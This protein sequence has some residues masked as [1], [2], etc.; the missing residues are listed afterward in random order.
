MGFPAGVDVVTISDTLHLGAGAAS[1]VYV[2]L[3]PTTQVQLNDAGTLLP[4]VFEAWSGSDGSLR[5]EAVATDSENISPASGWHYELTI[6]RDNKTV[7]DAV[8]VLLPKSVPTLRLGDL[9]PLGDLDGDLVYAPPSTLMDEILAQLAADPSSAV[10]AELASTY[11]AK[12]EAA[13][14]YAKRGRWPVITITTDSG[15]DPSDTENYLNGDYTITDTDGE[16]LHEGGLRLRGRGNTTWGRPKKPWR[17]NFDVKTQPLGMTASQRNWALLADD[18]DPAKLGNITSFTLGQQMDGLNWTPEYRIVELV[19]NDTYRGLYRLTDLVRV[20]SG[21]VPGDP[22]EDEGVDVTTGTLLF[23]ITNK[24]SPTQVGEA[25]EPGFFTSIYNQ[26]V[27]FDT[28]EEPDE[29]QQ[30]DIEALFTALEYAIRYGDWD[31]WKEL[32][33]ATSFADWWLVNELLRNADSHFWSSVKIHRLADDGLFRL[34]PLWDHDL[35]FGLTTTEARLDPET[36]GTRNAAWL[37]RLWY[38][39]DFRYL[40]QERWQALLDALGDYNA[41]ID[42]MIDAQEAAIDRD[43]RKWSRTVYTPLEADARKRW[44]ATRIAWL[45]EQLMADP[46]PVTDTVSELV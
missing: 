17:I 6:K 20:E 1:K 9:Q 3:R 38:D 37:T 22:V 40:A 13:T 36:W 41:W 26:W 5:L 28:P 29:D 7:A 19:L 21:R 12:D 45:D 2:A 14:A 34:G 42:R 35:T 31:G 43:S 46:N 4:V 27:V 25:A 44:L 23:E 30:A 11:V 32:A 33:D 39:S 15:S 18:F 16:V 24:E 10:S 8:P